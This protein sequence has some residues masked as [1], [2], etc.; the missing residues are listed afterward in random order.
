MGCSLSADSN[1]TDVFQREQPKILTQSNPPP[2]D[3]RVS[4]TRR[5]IVAK[6]SEIAQWPHRRAYRKTNIALSNG[7]ISDLPRPPLPQN[8]YPNAPIVICRISM[9]ISPQRVIRS[10]PIHFMFRSLLE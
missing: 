10:D 8:R 1:I 9:A 2:V 6:W 7:T 3:L 5:Q 4:D